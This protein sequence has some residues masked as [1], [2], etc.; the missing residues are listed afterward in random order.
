MDREKGK[1]IF[2]LVV[3]VGLLVASLFT[4]LGSYFTRDAILNY[5]QPLIAR[6]KV[7]AVLIFILAMTLL[8]MLWVPRLVMTAVAGALFG[9]GEGFLYAMAGSTTAGVVGYW[10]AKWTTA[11]YFERKIEGKWWVKYL[12]FTH[13]NAFW[14]ILL[15]RICP[16]THYEVIN[17][18]CGTSNIRFGTFFWSSVLGIVP[19]T[20][21]YVM[22]GDAILQGQ[23]RDFWITMA[24]L[25]VFF[26][27]TM[28]GFY[29]LVVSGPKRHGAGHPPAPAAEA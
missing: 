29:Y 26:V 27:V 28:A 6:N 1:T 15:A 16:L 22:M 13:G 4:P 5:V 3:T 24:V 23:A 14:L 12:D 25:A 7:E 21:I 20:F 10:F 8:P 11:R 18:L 17:Y 2:F 19:G 9:V